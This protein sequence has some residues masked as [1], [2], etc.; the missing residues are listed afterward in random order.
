MA[1]QAIVP[2]STITILVAPPPPPPPPPSQPWRFVA[3]PDIKVRSIA[4]HPKPLLMPYFVTG[5]GELAKLCR[6]SD[7][8]PK[9]DTTLNEGFGF[10]YSVAFN[11]DGSLLATGC[12]DESK[13]SVNLWSFS[14]DNPPV[15]SLVA[16]LSGHTKSVR[17]VAFHSTGRLLASGSSDHKVKL[18]KISPDNLSAECMATVHDHTGCVNS[19]AFHQK[20]PSYLA[21][22]S[23]DKTAI[24]WE[25]SLDQPEGEP[26]LLATLGDHTTFI[27][28][29]AFHPEE[30]LLATA[31][32]DHTARLYRFSQESPRNVN[33]VATL[34]VCKTNA[35]YSLAF[36]PAL[37]YLVTGS[38]DKTAKVWNFTNESDVKCVATLEGHSSGV[39]AVAF[40]K[41]MYGTLATA[42]IDGTV[43]L[44]QTSDILRLPHSAQQQIFG[45]ELGFFGE[46][47]NDGSISDTFRRVGAG[48]DKNK[49]GMTKNGGRR[50]RRS[51]SRSR[52]RNHRRSRK[53][54]GRR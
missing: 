23:D 42:S 52:R 11:Y 4:F 50:R 43:K 53:Q 46:R 36:H 51:R 7:T 31:S 3:I 18:W 15:P 14:M 21:T 8:P 34:Q 33:C 16:S 17:C 40:N 45:K 1:E 54:H 6:Y 12:G 2:I 39:L 27:S 29:V 26:R 44:W 35:V 37:P 47:R 24:L 38:G 19:V 49:G 41:N 48:N 10:V 30:L 20:Y 28:S 13:N 5:C 9:E 22:G 32:H 25:V